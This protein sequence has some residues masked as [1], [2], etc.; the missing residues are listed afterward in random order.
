MLICDRS[1][2]AKALLL[3]GSSWVAKLSVVAWNA[4]GTHSRKRR[5]R[6]HCLERRQLHCSTWRVAAPIVD[7]A[8]ALTRA[9]LSRAYVRLVMRT[10]FPDPH[11][12]SVMATAA[13]L[14]DRQLWTR[15]KARTILSTTSLSLAP[16]SF[17]Q[18]A[19]DAFVRVTT[20][21]KIHIK[22]P[23][24]LRTSHLRCLLERDRR[25]RRWWRRWWRRRWWRR[26]W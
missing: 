3:L 19:A 1:E 17:V 8:Q 23:T 25:R 14:V 21:T 15:A 13:P 16:R 18:A 22:R 4:A 11:V 24:E 10:L 20:N 12:L 26:W 6:L 2:L 5:I 9:V 7:C